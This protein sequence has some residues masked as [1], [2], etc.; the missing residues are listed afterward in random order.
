MS[1]KHYTKVFH[2]LYISIYGRVLSG[3]IL[4]GNVDSVECHASAVNHKGVIV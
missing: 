3:P 1:K 4:I 2:L